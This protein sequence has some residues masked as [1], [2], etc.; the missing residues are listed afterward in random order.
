MLSPFWRFLNSFWLGAETT[1]AARSIL[2]FG[3]LNVWTDLLRLFAWTAVVVALLLLPVSRKLARERAQINTPE[4]NGATWQ[5]TYS[6]QPTP[7]SS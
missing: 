2:Y 5:P 7:T 6:Q 3:G 1:N 4:R